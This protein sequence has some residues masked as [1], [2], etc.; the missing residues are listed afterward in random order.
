MLSYR[1]E[2]EFYIDEK[3]GKVPKGWVVKKLSECFEFFPT[4]SYPRENLSE[5]GDCYYI[6]YGDIH[7]KFEGF[8]D[9]KKEK[10]P[11]IS[12]KMASR[13][14]KIEEGDLIIADAS[15]DYDGVGKA[16][17]ILNIGNKKAI[18]G[19]HTL[20]LRAQNDNFVNG[21]KGYVLN[22]ENVR[23]KILRSATGIKV[24]SVSKSGLKGVLIPIPPKIEQR[25]I[26][27]I[28]AKVDQAI[29]ATK[30]SIAKAERVKKAL[31]QNLL[32]GKLKANGVWRNED[33][34]YK[35]ERFGSVPQGWK[36]DKLETT[37]SICQYGLNATSVEGGDYPM[38]RMNNIVHGKMVSEPMVYINLSEDEFQK[39][40][41]KE[42]DILFNRTNS[43]DLVGKLGI[44]KLEGDYVF[45]SYLIRLT[46]NDKNC[47]DYIN[48][49]LNSYQGQ[50]KLR[51][52]ATPSVSQ[53][54]INAGNVRKLIIPIPPKEE[55]EEI[56]LKIASVD[57]L[58]GSR[59]NKVNK[60]VRLKTALMQNLLTGKVR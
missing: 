15:E 36:Y 24:Y 23:L 56:A 32:T 26:A 34:F 60:L 53:A 2:D 30:N 47:P 57:N 18:S 5:L 54:N 3:F 55:Q 12:E 13:F 28:L 22:N 8:I 9:F 44:F 31:V 48:Y 11:F 58:L 29:S 16:V 33:E 39:Y 45:A 38:F 20:H 51:S 49:Y 17:E 25:R 14:T 40:R 42:N 10:L 27:A 21:F 46:V 41:V 50:C 19:L 6:H 43:L 1:N 4:A 7:T 52:K 37:L 59:Q 35:D